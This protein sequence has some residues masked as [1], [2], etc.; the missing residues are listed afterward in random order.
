[1][2]LVDVYDDNGKP[3]GRVV[4]RGSK[5]EVFSPNEHIAVSIIFIENSKGEY[6]IQKTSKE[7]GGD[8]SSTGGHVDKGE[9]PDDVIIREVKEE[10][11]ID[12]SNDKI[13]KLGFRLLDFPVRFLYYLKKDIDI[14]SIKVQKNEVDDVY[15]M[16]EKEVKSLIYNLLMNK[17]H[18]L[19]F[20]EI[21][22]HKYNFNTFNDIYLKYKEN[23]KVEWENANVFNLYFDDYCLNVSV[24]EA[25]L[26]KRVKR[27]NKYKYIYTTNHVHFLE[28]EYSKEWYKDTCKKIDNFIEKYKEK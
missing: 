25:M 28:D 6:L 10:L 24:D 15:Y 20:R 4:P 9:S 27:F 14:N 21:L 8:F 17:G 11:G 5:D 19:L 2:E 22:K 13:E 18:S 3:T 26:L 12:I 16:S 1:M 23:Y 7:K